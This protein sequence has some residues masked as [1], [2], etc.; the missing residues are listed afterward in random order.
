MIWM[1]LHREMS[2]KNL[3]WHGN[4]PIFTTRKN[5]IFCNP[6]KGNIHFWH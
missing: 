2:P 4:I 3:Q 6:I 1:I 5:L